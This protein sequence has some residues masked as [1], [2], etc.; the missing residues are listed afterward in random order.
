MH[1]KLNAKMLRFAAEKGFIRQSSEEERF[2]SASPEGEDWDI[3]RIKK[4]GGSEAWGV[5]G[6]VI[7]DKK[8]R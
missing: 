6:K 1:S 8:K 5:W 2:R 7:G 4:Q 3:C